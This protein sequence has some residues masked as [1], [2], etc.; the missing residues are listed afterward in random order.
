M[1]VGDNMFTINEIHPLTHFLRNARERVKHLKKTRRPEVLTVN[2]KPALVVQDA[3]AYEEMAELLESLK[4][5]KK[6]AEAFDRGE[7][8][9]VQSFF[10]EFEKK[11]GIDGEKIRD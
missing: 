2:G 4:A 10:D 9:S 7:G 8:R 11:H 3:E 6:A 1:C 5:I